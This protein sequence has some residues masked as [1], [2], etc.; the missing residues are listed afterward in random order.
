MTTRTKYMTMFSTWAETAAKAAINTERGLGKKFDEAFKAL[1]AENETASTEELV[2]LFDQAMTELED[3]VREELTT[4]F[5]DEKAT[6]S[7]VCPAFRQYKSDYRGLLALIGREA[8]K[9]NGPYNVKKKK[10]E[11]KNA[12]AT[13]NKG[14]AGGNDGA[15]D[16]GNTADSGSTGG[17]DM[18]KLPASVREHIEKAMVAL[19]KLDAESAERIAANFET[20]AWVNVKRASKKMGG[21]LKNVA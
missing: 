18:S 1:V 16:G 14:P 4:A 8:A 19:S 9:V 11:L 3:H 7:K 15:G 2:V 17:V 20:A 6:L 10:A 13:E 21:A 5:E 12:K